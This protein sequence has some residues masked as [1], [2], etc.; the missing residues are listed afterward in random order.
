MTERGGGGGGRQ[1]LVAVKRRRVL[2]QRDRGARSLVGKCGVRGAAH[3]L[4]EPHRRLAVR[5]RGG[6]DGGRRREQAEPLL[7]TAPAATRYRVD[8]LID[9]FLPNHSL[10]RSTRSA[11]TSSRASS[12]ANEG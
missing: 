10:R 4:D 9:S 1:P 5:P 12:I 3:A 6:A 7:E 2:E 11:D 8:E